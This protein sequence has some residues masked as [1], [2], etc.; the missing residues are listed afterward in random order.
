MPQTFKQESKT[1]QEEF[2]K[3][4]FGIQKANRREIWDM[5]ATIYLI[6]KKERDIELQDNQNRRVNKGELAS[7][8]HE[9]L[10]T[11]RE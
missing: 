9:K 1:I 3:E 10:N 4:R 7:E 11:L 2:E 8:N 5:E 6:E